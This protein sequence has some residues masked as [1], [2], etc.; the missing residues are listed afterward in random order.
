MKECV[1]CHRKFKDSL[2][3]CPYDGRV[4]YMLLDDKYRLE[5]PLGKGGMGQVYR[6]THIHLRTQ[7]AIKLLLPNLISDNTAIERFNREAQL[8][9]QIKHP[10][11]VQ[12]S[13]FGITRDEQKIFYL[14]ME[15]L[16]G[17]TL[18]EKIDAQKK[19]PYK[20]AISIMK[21]VCEA[22]HAAHSNQIIHRDLKPSN[23]FL[24][25]KTSNHEQ[26]K[27]LD[28]G[29]AKLNS[30]DSTL[31]GTGMIVGTHYYMS[32][33]QCS[34]QE[35]DARSDIYSLAIV[36]YE[37]LTGRVPFQHSNPSVILYKHVNELPKPIRQFSPEIPKEIEEVIMQ[38][39]EKQ[40]EKRQTSTLQFSKELELSIEKNETK[41]TLAPKL[42]ITNKILFASSQ[43]TNE[44]KDD[45][46]FTFPI[47]N[48]VNLV[49]VVASNNKAIAVLE[50]Q[51]VIENSALSTNLKPDSKAD[52][53]STPVLLNSQQN[54]VIFAP[55]KEINSG[56][57]INNEKL[58]INSN[59]GIL[60][61][62]TDSKPIV[63]T[64]SIFFTGT[65]S[66]KSET[67]T[68]K[69]I[70]IYGIAVLSLIP[71]IV[72]MFWPKESLPTTTQEKEIIPKGMIFIPGDK[73]IMGNEN[74]P[75]E[76]EKPEHQVT[77][78]SF[79][80]D[81]TEVTN[82]EYDKFVKATNYPPPRT[83]I[84]KRYPL[85]EARYP[86]TGVSW[87]DAVAYARWIGKRLPTEEEWEYSA[88]GT[89]RLLY[90]WGNKYDQPNANTKES[91]TKSTVSVG[92]YPN[93]ASPF[94]IKDLAGNVLEWTDSDYQ[95]YPN[96][97]ATP[98]PGKKVV[99]GGSYNLDKTY[100]TTTSR[101]ALS[102]ETWRPDLGFR[103]AKNALEK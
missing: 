66:N 32:P 100:A 18:K 12:V 89:E 57:E 87:I 92:S 86:V 99:R 34:G 19:I 24:V 42:V 36:L 101:A 53:Q 96:S 65:I 71:I 84:N 37:M 3:F 95:L 29:I 41:Q 73:F 1:I 50:H 17:V 45:E 51:E 7:V 68:R 60:N 5:E 6:A 10:N 91:K 55:T 82:E 69:R 52:S 44:L 33:E 31:T 90:P 79:Y 2:T 61:I 20:E 46:D 81:E 27:V 13:D 93:G 74:S 38:A 16:T 56:E 88:R 98:D 63:R 78:R 75:V 26:A 85:A 35:L 62:K 77:V 48:K 4:L 59:S 25:R 21:S 58:Y 47:D 9:A 70:F 15:L 54:P 94:G 8:M 28:F 64:D 23:I 22:V 14:V 39:L 67:S 40:P 43:P 72:V 80:I 30:S 102:S 11:V 49:E 76:A 103:C 97:R 83:W